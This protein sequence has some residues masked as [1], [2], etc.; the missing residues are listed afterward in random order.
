M[1][2]TWGTWQNVPQGLEPSVYGPFTARLKPRPFKTRL[3]QPVL[4]PFA[5]FAHAAV[6][7]IVG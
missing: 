6:H 3:K 5:V 1:R 4:G 7:G 2:G